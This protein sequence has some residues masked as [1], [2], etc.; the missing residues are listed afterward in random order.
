MEIIIVTKLI[1]EVRIYSKALTEEEIEYLYNNPGNQPPNKPE[2]PSGPPFGKPGV[3]YTYTT[4][5]TDPEGFQ[6]YYKWSWGDGS[7]SDWLGPYDSGIEIS[8]SHSWSKGSFNITVK[9]KDVHDAESDWS[10]PLSITMPRNKAIKTSLFINLLQDHQ[11][12][13][14]IFHR[15]LQRLGLK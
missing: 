6:V 1:D 15:L 5:T 10:D 11:N 12:L 3:E 4:R 8:A 7:F 2:R 14:P 13:F 9:A